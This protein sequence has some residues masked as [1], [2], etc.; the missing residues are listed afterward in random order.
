[1]FDTVMIAACVA[2]AL[3]YSVYRLW[4]GRRTK[5]ACSSCGEAAT[6]NGQALRKACGCADCPLHER[7]DNCH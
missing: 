4:R 7:C 1:M 5:G 2:A 3:G 6:A